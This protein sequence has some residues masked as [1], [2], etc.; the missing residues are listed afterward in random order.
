LHK[1]SETVA[2]LAEEVAEEKRNQT[3][4]ASV[5]TPATG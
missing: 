1:P 4:A 3:P 5:H 2:T